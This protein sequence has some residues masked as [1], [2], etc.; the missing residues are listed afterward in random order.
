MMTTPDAGMTPTGN[1]MTGQSLYSARGCFS[2]HGAN[3]EGTGAGPNIS[4]NMT[5][6]IGQW[7]LAEFTRAIRES[8]GRDGVR[9]CNSMQPYS[10]TDQQL[11]DLFAFLKSKDSTSPERGPIDCR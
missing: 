9:F 5:A 10:V 2:C 4:G 1:V 3:A 11:A 8:I 7:T 6:G